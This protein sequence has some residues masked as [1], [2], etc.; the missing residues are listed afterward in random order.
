[1]RVGSM[2]KT[3]KTTTTA[4][5]ALALALLIPALAALH[6]DPVRA[7]DPAQRPTHADLRYGPHERNVLDFWKAASDRPAPLVL[8]IHGGG[9]RGGD[10][11]SVNRRLL[12]EL[13][14]AGISVAALNYRLLAQA[15]LPAAHED[16]R[17]ALQF[18]RSRADELGFDPHRVGAFGGSAGAQICMW[19]AFHDDM[20]QPDSD[21]PI[22]RQSSRL[23]CVATTG[24]Q[25]T[26]DF[27]WWLENVPG[28]SAPHRPASEY[29]G[30]HAPEKLARIV[31]DVS[32]LSLITNDDPPIFM[33][34]RMAPDAAAPEDPARARGWRVHHVVFGVALKKRMDEL[35]IEADLHYPGA[36]TE[37]RSMAAF[38]IDRMQKRG[39]G[40]ATKRRRIADL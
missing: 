16:C 2:T 23:A 15:K 10:K 9:F 8:F 13:L 6:P 35:G 25:T 33:S 1:M 5:R 28:Y 30:D 39:A 27:A 14:D 31:R 3:T 17:L 11:R 34:Y 21:D 29:F 22:R 37:Y 38:F 26:M 36:R 12:G 20:A 18:L 7:Q 19:L 40:A 24:G 32:A 4:S